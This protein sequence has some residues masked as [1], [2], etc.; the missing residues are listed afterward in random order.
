MAGP[1]FRGDLFILPRGEAC[2]LPTIASD[3]PPSPSNLDLFTDASFPMIMNCE[4]PSRP[5][6]PAS[7]AHSRAFQILACRNWLEAE[8]FAVVTGLETAA[9]LSHLMPDLRR[10]TVFTDCQGSIRALVAAAE[11]A[12]DPLVKRAVAASV[13][14]D[15]RGVRAVVRWC[16]GHAG[17]EGN[18]RADELAQEVRYYNFRH[19]VPREQPDALAGYE[20]PEEYVERARR[21]DWWKENI[22]RQ[23]E[24][25]PLNAE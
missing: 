25:S 14:L 3:G 1:E 6:Q 4:G 10:V 17:I 9:L 23:Q 5:S 18:E 19:L 12:S 11:N 20:I 21:G 2:I 8:L 24:P 7:A 15:A 16:P 13:K 22:P